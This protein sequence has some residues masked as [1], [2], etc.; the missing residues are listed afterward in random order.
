MTHLLEFQEQ[1]KWQEEEH[2]LGGYEDWLAA[3]AEE[4]LSNEPKPI[5]CDPSEEVPVLMGAALFCPEVLARIIDLNKDWLQQDPR[6]TLQ[7][8]NTLFPACERG[9]LGLYDILMR[10]G[11]AL[12]K[13]GYSPNGW[14]PLTTWTF[15]G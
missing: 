6:T 10:V 4:Q 7:V 3:H 14:K 13:A 5:P 9:D 1:Q 12:F 15:S 8:L 2:Y 11:D